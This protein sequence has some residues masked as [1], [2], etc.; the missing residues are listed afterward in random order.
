MASIESHYEKYIFDN[1]K[2][3]IAICNAQ[4]NCIE[5]VNPAFANIYG[6]EQDELIGTSA[7]KIFT[8]KCLVRLA[9]FEKSLSSTIS[10]LFFE[11]V[12]TRKD[13]T[14][15]H[16]SVHIT[17]IQDENGTVLQRISN[18]MD[19]SKRK[20]QEEQ[21]RKKEQEFRTLTA[22]VDIPIYRYDKE[23]RRIYINPAVEKLV[24]KPVSSFLGKTPL[25]ANIIETTYSDDVMKSLQN[26]LHTGK[27]DSIELRFILPDNSQKHFIHN[28][29]PE[30]APDGTVESILA[31]GHDITAEKELTAKEEAYRTLAENSP[32]IIIRYNKDCKRTYVNPAFTK[33][34]DISSEI[35][36]D[37]TTDIPWDHY[38]SILNMSATEYQER[39]K[40]V[41]QDG[42]KDSFSIE[43]HILKSGD[44]AAYALNI[45]AEKSTDGTVIGALVI[46]HD[47]TKYK[48]MEKQLQ[49]REQEFRALAENSPDTIARFNSECLRTYIN[50][51]F[52][53]L[54]GFEAKQILGKP[55]HQSTPIPEHLSVAFENHLR[56]VLK[57]GK[58]F[59]METP[60]IGADGKKGFGHVRIVP[61]F[62]KNG[63]VKSVL[64]IG[65][66]ITELK[67]F[68]N[69]LKRQKDFQDT[70]LKSISEAGLGVHVFEKGHYI[71]T[72]N[73]E[74]AEEYGF[75][76]NISTVKPSFL[77]AVHPDDKEKVAL[78]YQKRL[79]GKDVPTTYTIKLLNKHG[80]TRDHEVSVVI[81][82]NTDPIQ[83]LILTKDVTERRNIEKKIE[84]IAHH[85]AL[86]GLPNRILAQEKAKEILTHTKCEKDKTALLFIDLDGFKTINDS[87]GHSIGDAMLQMVT[88]RL[89]GCIRSSDTLSRQGGDEFLLIL[90]N[91]KTTEEVEIVATKLLYEFKNSFQINNHLIS[92]SASIG[93]AL[94]PDHGDTFEELLQSA[95]S[96]MYQA[97]ESGKNNYCFYTKQMKHN[98]TGLFQMQND[99]KDALAKEEFILHYQPQID[100]CQHKIVGV[101]ALIR[102]QHPTMG[103]IPPMS[104]IPIAESSGQIVQI[105]EWVLIEACK[106][107]ALWNQQGRDI[108]V[109]INIS[110]IQFKRGNLEKVVKHALHVSGLEPKYLELELT[111]SI[112]INNT[113]TILQTVKNIKALGIQLSID[114]F[115]TGYSSLAYLKRFAVDKLKIDQSFIRDILN[116]KEDASI[117]KAIIQMA[118]SF[119]LK[120]IAEGVE[121]ED[122]LALVREF[123]CDEVQGY[124][125]AK[126]MSAE[127]F[128][129]YKICP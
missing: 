41:I 87:L 126:P 31:V 72:N 67:E 7:E 18:I 15:I 49:E 36:V 61:E 81:I 115:G 86:T 98:F 103:M 77:D 102:W 78:I 59:S 16:V 19:I 9:E 79:A 122:V 100:L 51:S 22:N 43:I 6:Y 46:G 93:I 58:E 3:G 4:S 68:E 37:H 114:D 25:E 121:N 123:G 35:L 116:D 70:L 107:A 57:T 47:L 8:P 112:L 30:F 62:G 21:L 64:S 69:E 91:I 120:S 24:G 88:S 76:G 117:V 104:F 56:E 75:E 17:V 29:I 23:C 53:R 90:P 12:H 66:D 89:Q 110:A 129:H 83:T 38:F 95:D 80:K 14:Q 96:A 84:F 128:E 92:T 119:N 101:E 40:N 39:V 33:L 108:V 52:Q 65:R 106:Q 10:D 71:Y 13:K 74:L 63:K 2:V 11:D 50:P 109:A 85:D 54:F 26:V 127:D 5:I 99:L 73:H 111:E 32:N 1:V 28:H 44:Y 124:H 105:G 125:F 82:P 60:Y 42:T 45:V 97:K 34:I 27:A 94:H 20:E 48:Q 113:E 55:L 118:K